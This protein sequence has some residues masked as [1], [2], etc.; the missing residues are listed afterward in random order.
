MLANM[1]AKNKEKIYDASEVADY[2]IYLATI[3]LGVGNTRELEMGNTSLPNGLPNGD[4]ISHTKLQKMLYFAQAHFLGN[5]SRPLF[6]NHIHAWQYGPVVEEVY[7]QYSDKKYEPLLKA[8]DETQISE[9]DKAVLKGIW[10]AYGRYSAGYLTALSH[11][12][13]PWKEAYANQDNDV[14]SPERL[15]IYYAPNLN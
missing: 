12:H 9:F 13:L 14:I 6:S 4:G 10:D 7:Q 8:E 11:E 15:K 5:L 1:S 3:E 2:F